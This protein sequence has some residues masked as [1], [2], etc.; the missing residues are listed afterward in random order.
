MTQFFDPLLRT[1]D[2]ERDEEKERFLSHRL[3]GTERV[4]HERDV[5]ALAM[6]YWRD[7]GSNSLVSR[8]GRRK[9]PRSPRKESLPTVSP[10]EDNFQPGMGSDLT[11]LSMFLTTTVKAR[12]V[13]NYFLS[14][15]TKDTSVYSESPIH[16]EPPP[17]E[18][19]LLQIGCSEMDFG[20][21]SFSTSAD[22]EEFSPPSS[23]Y[24]EDERNPIYCD[25]PESTAILTSITQELCTLNLQLIALAHSPDVAARAYAASNV[26]TPDSAFWHLAIDPDPS[27]RLTLVTNNKCPVDVLQYLEDDEVVEIARRAHSTMR[28]IAFLSDPR[29]AKLFQ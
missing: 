27:V 12:A 4:G 20:P 15:K 9:R 19:E 16:D 23:G 17:E 14:P 28:M 22:D 10:W 8:G 6:S 13:S 24:P 29:S 25:D 5:R 3:M 7:V 2:D 1:P 18:V 11:C 26:N 21:A